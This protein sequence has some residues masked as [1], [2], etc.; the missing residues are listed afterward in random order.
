SRG[1]RCHH[2]LVWLPRLIVVVVGAVAIGWTP[3]SVSAAECA[4]SSTA[5]GLDAF[6]ASDDAAGLAGA[7][8]PHA[9]ELPDGRFLW[10]FQDAFLGSDDRLDGD[11]FA[12]N[13]ALVQ[14]GD[15]FE[16]RRPSG[17]EGDSWIGS[18]VESSL[19]NWLW[20]L[21]A[22]IGDDGDLWLFLAEV[23]NPNETG[24]ARGAL[25]VGTWIARY[26]LPDLQLIGMQPA[27]DPSRS[28]FGY[29]VVSD[30]EWSYLYGHCYRQFDDAGL[31]GFDS[32]CSPHAYVARVPHGDFDAEPQYWTDDGWSLNRDARVPVLTGTP[33][34]PVSVQRFG[35]TYVA[36]SDVGDW[37]GAEV[38]VFTASAP[39]GPW[40]EATRYTP[41]TRC[42]DECNN[43]G[44]FV[45][46]NLEGDQV[47]IAHSNNAWDMDDAVRDASLYRTSI[48]TVDVPGL[49]A[50]NLERSPDLVLARA[51]P[52]PVPDSVPESPP[53]TAAVEATE[54]TATRSSSTP[55]LKPHAVNGAWLPTLLAT[56]IAAVLVLVSIAFAPI[57]A[58]SIARTSRRSRFRRLRSRALSAPEADRQP[59]EHHPIVDPSR[60]PL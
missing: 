55:S 48:R 5:T 24:A 40:T 38:V 4:E 41:D 1:R 35:D 9:I 20:P 19:S 59:R 57:T 17:G 13:A 2:G 6:F 8:Y 7:D 27:P 60:P 16:L 44:A 54:V 22:A 30:G 29:S 49:T 33:S 46:P 18:W 12:H 10:Y 26:A 53:T 52:D 31:V 39:Q 51:E 3:T 47:V 15:C 34:M 37:F 11:T 56:L 45:L 23:Q 36:A 50:A 25:P 28:L 14:D 42:G 43:Y 58:L 21:D 32:S